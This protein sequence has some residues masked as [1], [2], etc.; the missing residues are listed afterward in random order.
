MKYIVLMCDKRCELAI[1]LRA[2]YIQQMLQDHL[3]DK[4]NINLHLNEKIVVLRIETITLRPGKIVLGTLPITEVS[5]FGRTSSNNQSVYHNSTLY[6]LEVH[7]DK[8]L[9][10]SARLLV[11]VVAS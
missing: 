3:Q 10:F 4:A 2:S 9:I 5:Y 6:L 11:S 8:N 7:T 1:N